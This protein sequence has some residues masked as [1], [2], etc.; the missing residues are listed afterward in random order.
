LHNQIHAYN[1][2]FDRITIVTGP[3][4]SDAAVELTPK[5]WGVSVARR[6][7]DGRLETQVLRS[8]SVNTRQDPH[9]VAMLLW[10]DEAI[11]ALASE[12]GEAIHRRATR[13]QLH[14]RLASVLSFSTL[15]SYV[16]SRLIARDRTTKR[17]QSAPNDGLLHHD[18]NCSGFHSLI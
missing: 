14:D 3:M 7:T 9:S 17:P 16:T 18:A 10:R 8:A 15:R 6:T 5:W 13:R 11:E 1:R 4:F 12:T 2:V